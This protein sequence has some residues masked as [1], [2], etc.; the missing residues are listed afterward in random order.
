MGQHTPGTPEGRRLL[1]HE[2]THAVQQH[3]GAFPPVQTQAHGVVI[4]N[5]IPSERNEAL[6]GASGIHG[7]GI[8]VSG[9]CSDGPV[10]QDFGQ[11][12][13][14]R[15]SAGVRGNS[16]KG[17]LN[18]L[19]ADAEAAESARTVHALAYTVG[20]HVVFGAG[21]YDPRSP[22]GRA[23]L[24]HELTHTMQQQVTGVPVLQRAPVPEEPLDPLVMQV[25]AVAIRT[26]TNPSAQAYALTEEFADIG[27]FSAQEQAL[28]I[29]A[30][31]RLF[32]ERVALDFAEWVGRSQTNP[33]ELAMEL[34]RGPL[35]NL[36][37][38]I[39]SSLFVAAFRPAEARVNAFVDGFLEGAK[40]DEDTTQKVLGKL[41]VGPTAMVVFNGA[42]LAG[43]L[44]GTALS[45]ASFVSTLAHL[46]EVL[47]KLDELVRAL[48]SDEGV[49]LAHDL[50]VVAGD[51]WAR[52]LTS[53]GDMSLPE[54]SYW[55]GKKLGPLL[56]GIII[57]LVTGAV[58]S[59]AWRSWTLAREGFEALVDLSK[60]RLAQRLQGV[61]VLDKPPTAGKVLI[62]KEGN[63]EYWAPAEAASELTPTAGAGRPFV[64][65]TEGGAPAGAQV[66]AIATPAPATQATGATVAAGATQVGKLAVQALETDIAAGKIVPVTS[67]PPELTATLAN[68]RALATANP[69]VAG[70]IERVLDLTPVV[71]KALQDPKA[72]GRALEEL[73]AAQLQ[74]PSSVTDIVDRYVEG[75]KL[76][77][78]QRGYDLLDV[79]YDE[80][81]QMATF[82]STRGG[83]VPPPRPAG[84]GL[85]TDEDFINELIGSGQMFIDRPALF[86]A[87]V[88]GGKGAHGALS[89]FV[90]DLVADPAL[91]PYGITSVEYRVLLK[92]IS[93]LPGGRGPTWGQYEFAGTDIWMKTYDALDNGVG[94][95]ESFW[96]PLRDLLGIEPGR[97]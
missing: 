11:A 62:H 13:V 93:M 95:P 49:A 55:M 96:P 75:A 12:G 84:G 14:A 25:E 77:A 60:L 46:P 76:L 47:K 43:A 83:P 56:A 3:G 38:G 24:A 53:V 35:G 41:A 79:T 2:L 51:G 89:H 23:L 31:A 19:Y 92:R 32:P 68:V 70:D 58:F 16:D 30:I 40:F 42:F 18:F 1:A 10:R 8:D 87:P 63:I 64:A 65:A 78:R 61:R 82:T 85:L 9:V 86:Q 29:G 80:A 33:Y 37:P 57:A 28:V 7:A 39:L 48:L 67:M 73:E 69:G 50:G 45:I 71:W 52:E 59:L 97:L 74:V 90:Q 34:D 5:D 94:Q 15:R 91:Q 4:N 66:P 17:R 26:S 54:L 22:R 72:Y 20:D 36:L 44:H 6:I 81:S 21:R 27:T 88:K